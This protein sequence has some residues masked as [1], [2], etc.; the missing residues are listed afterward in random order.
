LVGIV[1]NA[2]GEPLNVGRKTRSI[3]P[4]LRRALKSRD[5]GCRFPGCTHKKYVDHHHIHHWANGGET[6]ASNLVTLCVFHHRK[7]HEGGVRIEILDDGAFRFVKPNGESFDSVAPGCTKPMS[8]W[9]ELE[10]IHG[11]KID[12]KTAATKWT[13]ET[14]D[15]GTG[16]EWLV[17]RERMSGDVSAET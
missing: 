1:E 3:P 15:Y 6:K 14:M 12:K 8:D 7:V 16:V 17:G 13:G 4:A 5:Q 11:Q 9:R 2:E 10:K